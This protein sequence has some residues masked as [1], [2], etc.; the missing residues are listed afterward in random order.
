MKICGPQYRDQNKNDV[1]A[2]SNRR[3]HTIQPTPA[4]I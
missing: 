1:D 3:K 2:E 4:T